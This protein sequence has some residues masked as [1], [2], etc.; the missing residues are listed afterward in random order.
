MVKGVYNLPISFLKFKLS[1]ISNCFKI[2]KDKI[3]FLFIQT[4]TKANPYTI[5]YIH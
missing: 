5:M 4:V 1:N 3:K 2:F